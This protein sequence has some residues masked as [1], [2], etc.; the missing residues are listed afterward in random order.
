MNYE[1]Q[2]YVRLRDE[3]IT[4]AKVRRNPL[5]FETASPGCGY[6][7]FPCGCCRST[8]LVDNYRDVVETTCARHAGM[9]NVE[10]TT[11]NEVVQTDI[12]KVLKAK[13]HEY[14]LEQIKNDKIKFKTYFLGTP[15]ENMQAIDPIPGHYGCGLYYSESEGLSYGGVKLDYPL[16]DEIIRIAKQKTKAQRAEELALLTEKERQAQFSKLTQIAIKLGFLS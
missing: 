13:L 7:V 1:E 6:W 14:V 5:Y 16:A 8:C 12:E 2:G 4:E 15:K 3:K 11:L 10:N 9:V